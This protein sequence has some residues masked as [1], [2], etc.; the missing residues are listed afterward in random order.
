MAA[1]ASPA[2]PHVQQVEPLCPSNVAQLIM[3][4]LAPD[5]AQR[6]QNAEEFRGKLLACLLE[7]DAAA[8]P[9][10]ASRFMRE[11][12]SAEYQ[13]ERK[14]LAQLKETSP[15]AEQQPPQPQ[16]APAAP[17]PVRDLKPRIQRPPEEERTPAP[18]DLSQYGMEQTSP[19]A[20]AAETRTGPLS[21]IPTPKVGGSD[22][23]PQGERETLPG[24]VMDPLLRSQ[25]MPNDDDRATG[26]HATVSRSG[27][28]TAELSDA[29]PT[30]PVPAQTQAA[31]VAAMNT[32][33]P[34]PPGSD[35]VT[36]QI[37]MT[38]PVSD[39]DL[40]S[41]VIG[42][43]LGSI[44]YPAPPKQSAGKNP[45]APKLAPSPVLI[46]AASV[47]TPEVIAPL[48]KA[49]LEKSRP[50]ENIVTDR[51]TRSRRTNLVIILMPLLA[52]LGLA[53]LVGWNVL[54][55]YQTTEDEENDRNT[56]HKRSNT[57]DHRV[58]AL[59]KTVV[60]DDEPANNDG[61]VADTPTVTP[62]PAPAAT[63]SDLEKLPPV[64]EPAPV[65]RK[66]KGGK[67]VSPSEECL[68]KLRVYFNQVETKLEQRSA[69]SIR[70]QLDGMEGQ[71]RST[72][73][74]R[75]AKLLEGCNSLR[76]KIQAQAK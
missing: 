58:R 39:P 61:V 54:R 8:G 53:G 72:P 38:A 46:P 55:G 25:M 50:D 66:T 51:G 44:S 17:R 60:I 16:P 26:P 13:A 24:I 59:P 27:H 33:E 56:V 69:N 18:T 12:F 21:F 73:A 23:H 30:R 32:A 47:R 62:P 15:R 36:S 63:D 76:D 67:A 20:R 2:I 4:A 57:D 42:E 29:V 40:P 14:L 19:G 34:A 65:V 22:K 68:L 37:Q 75:D 71:A 43:A 52:V 28:A 45:P 64:K 6:F 5:P 41:I 48:P 1:V 74:G 11:T 3:R 31:R 7:I 49:L 10:S 35:D 9:E 70:M